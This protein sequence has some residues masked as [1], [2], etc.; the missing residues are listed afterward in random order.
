MN[1]RAAA[2]NIIHQVANNGK[3]LS[4]V[5]PPMLDKFKEQRDQALLQ[6]LCYGVCRRYFFLSAIADALL[7]KPLKQKDQDIFC[8]L[9]VGLF[10]IIDMRIP[11]YAAVDETVAAVK[12]LNKVWAKGLVNAV[13]RNYQRSAETLVDKLTKND[14]S[15]YSHPA[16]IVGKL[17]KYWPS[18]WQQILNAN[19]AHPP[20][21][22]RVNTQKITR[23]NYLQK[24]Q[25]YSIEAD[26]IPETSA[27]IIV[28]N[29]MDALSLPGFKEGE[30]SVQDGAA[31]MSASLLEL[32][33][34]LTI[35]DACAA[36][37]GKT[38][39]ILETE[40]QLKKCIAI[41]NSENRLQLVK[42]NLQRLD[43]TAEC[44]QQD[45]GNTPAW[46]DGQLFDRILLDAPC[47]ASGVIR[48]HPDIKLLRRPE[49][50]QNLAKEQERLLTALWPLL[51]TDGIF[52]YVTCS[53]F[54][55]ENH[56]LL[57][58]FLT[59]H[60]D[61]K[62]EKIQAIWGLDCSVGKQILPGMHDMDGFYYA[63]LRKC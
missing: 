62:E 23:E 12:D 1:L 19:N 31:Q 57:E 16:W 47:S 56:R 30:I 41:D 8:L 37:G 13:L 42:D 3:S 22:L 34:G 51:K 27:G 35:L 61:A 43:L 25:K 2:A 6:A 54:P 18:H 26:I 38:A 55:E 50:I 7:E 45:A 60:P 14:E 52:L 63:R 9:L 15:A 32:V 21:A 40:P 5:L 53:I 59:T 17:K 4:D 28:K 44:I 58:R 29:P 24:L 10:Q 39:Q 46:W 11:D 33:P 49:D 20:F 36:P 48:R